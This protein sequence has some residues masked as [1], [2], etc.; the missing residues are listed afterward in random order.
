MKIFTDFVKKHQELF[1]YIKAADIHPH[2]H[3]MDITV[4]RFIPQ[5]VTPNKISIFRIFATPVV[6]FIILFGNYS[7][8]IV[9]FLLVAFTDAIDGSLAR[10]RHKV[11][12]FGMLIDPLADKLLIGSMV[13][14]LVFKYFDFWLGIAILFIEIAFI[15]SALV[16]GYRFKTIRMANGWGKIK[17]VLQ[18][19]AVFL[20]LLALLL[21][22]P[23]LLTAAAWVFGLAIGFAVL[24]L[25]AHGI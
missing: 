10:T 17:M 5:N 13:L 9:A 1:K 12:K 8:G 14:L 11:T 4:L 3:F 15:L 21:E 23:T 18:V 25:F 22:F 16:C 20:T 24:S 2:D 6:F 7:L 19:S